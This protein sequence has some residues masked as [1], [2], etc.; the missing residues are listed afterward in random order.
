LG[1]AADIHRSEE[2][3]RVTEAL[4]GS[5]VG[6]GVKEIMLELGAT[7]RN[8]TDVLLHRMVKDGEVVRTKK[9]VYCLSESVFGPV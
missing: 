2:R 8:A 6:L 7:N 4:R 9:G 1:P 5:V 3:A